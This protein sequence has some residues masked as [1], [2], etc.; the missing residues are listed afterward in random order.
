MRLALGDSWRKLSRELWNGYSPCLSLQKSKKQ[1]NLR[2]LANFD[3]MKLWRDK[4][5]WIKIKT[6]ILDCIKI[7][8]RYIQQSQQISQNWL[9]IKKLIE[10]SM[11]DKVVDCHYIISL[12]WN[13]SRTLYLKEFKAWTKIAEGCFDAPLKFKTPKPLPVKSKIDTSNY[14]NAPYKGIQVLSYNLEQNHWMRLNKLSKEKY[15]QML[16][17]RNSYIKWAIDKYK[18]RKDEVKEAN[19]SEVEQSC[20]E[21][22]SKASNDDSFFDFK[23]EWTVKDIEITLHP[24]VDLKGMI[25]VLLILCLDKISHKISIT[26]TTTNKLTTV[27]H[28]LLTSRKFLSL[29]SCII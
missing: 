6:G 24:L 12:C 11:K 3:V 20:A 25:I 22:E 15:Y 23:S 10:A 21:T 13:T 4:T 18:N 9:W 19:N 27:K 8:Y 29:Q 28:V 17:E 5:E 14:G 1:P 16:L 26:N 2:I 7:K